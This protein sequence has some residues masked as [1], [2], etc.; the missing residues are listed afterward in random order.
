[1]FLK[2]QVFIVCLQ[3]FLFLVLSFA[4]YWASS[5]ITQ[6]NKCYSSIDNFSLVVMWS[7][8]R[9]LKYIKPL[10]YHLEDIKQY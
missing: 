9:F 7:T 2:A 4:H 6:I 8:G 10:G 3:H 5:R 1:M